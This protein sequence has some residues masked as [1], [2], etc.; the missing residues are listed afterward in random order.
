[1]SDSTFGADSAGSDDEDRESQEATSSDDDEGI[2]ES[3]LP[4]SEDAPHLAPEIAAKAK[5]LP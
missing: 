4:V 5:G 2:D 1:M 3:G